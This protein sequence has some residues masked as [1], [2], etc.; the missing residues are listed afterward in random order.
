MCM[1][2]KELIDKF[3]TEH[4]FP[5]FR[6]VK[7]PMFDLDKFFASGPNDNNRVACISF[8]YKSALSISPRSW[9]TIQSMFSLTED[10]IIIVLNRWFRDNFPLLQFK[11]IVLT[12]YP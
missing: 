4:V 9:G 8:V 5:N 3:I 1:V 12:T 2:R 10:E 11:E 7:H 6:E